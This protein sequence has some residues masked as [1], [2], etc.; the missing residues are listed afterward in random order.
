MIISTWRH[1]TNGE[2]TLKSIGE[3]HDC[4]TIEQTPMAPTTL[5]LVNATSNQHVEAVVAE[6]R[7]LG[8]P[9]IPVVDCGD[10]YMA[11]DGSHRSMAAAKL[12]IRPTLNVLAPDELVAAD[13]LGT[14]FFQGRRRADWIAEQ[15]RGPHN[16]VLDINP[17][18][19]LAF[20]EAPEEQEDE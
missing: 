2:T 19:T 8:P 18:G 10:C 15:Y 1:P 14:D 13:D 4:Y 3:R 11:L 6:M 9:T 17:D 20:R 12:G 7:N 5:R 16:L